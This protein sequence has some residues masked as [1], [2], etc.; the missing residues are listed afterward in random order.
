MDLLFKK[1]KEVRNRKEIFNDKIN[2]Y[3]MTEYIDQNRYESVR[4]K[5]RFKIQ[6]VFIVDI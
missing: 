2:C 5:L 1:K 3:V 6:S 4:L